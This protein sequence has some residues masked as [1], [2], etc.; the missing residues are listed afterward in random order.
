MITAVGTWSTVHTLLQRE[1]SIPVANLLLELQFLKWKHVQKCNLSVN[2]AEKRIS[3]FFKRVYYGNL[4]H[5]SCMTYFYH[6]GQN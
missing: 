6:V 4:L 1:G 2:K 5:H 3:A